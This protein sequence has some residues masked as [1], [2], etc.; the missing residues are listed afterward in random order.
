MIKLL[1]D[2]MKSTEHKNEIKLDYD[3]ILVHVKA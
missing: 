3:F 1:I 2:D